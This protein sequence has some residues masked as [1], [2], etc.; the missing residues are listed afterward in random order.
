MSEMTAIGSGRAELLGRMS[1][2]NSDLNFLN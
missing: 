1:L 2:M